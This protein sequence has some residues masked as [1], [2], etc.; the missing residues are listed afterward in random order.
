MT[1][2]YHFEDFEPG[3]IFELGSVTVTKDDI[4][5]F[6]AE[7]DPQPFHLD[8]AAGKASMLGGLA[9]SG[10][11]TGS[12]V[13]RLLVD[14]LLSKSTC[15]GAPGIDQLKWQHPVYPQDILTA[16]AEILA[17]KDLR[18]RPDLG[19]VS[20]RIT[21]TNQNQKQVLFLENPILFGK[22][23]CSE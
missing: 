3:Q 12:M 18:S 10:W 17:R 13:M 4:I 15:Q 9:A 2:I 14:N 21:V 11:H 5:E 1:D 20:I 19:L 6:A 7:F 23:E 16:R 8:E 22:R